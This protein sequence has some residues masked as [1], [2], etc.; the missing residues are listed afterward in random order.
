MTTTPTP[1][2]PA[3]R[4]DQDHELIEELRRQL[5]LYR[6]VAWGLEPRPARPPGIARQMARRL[7]GRY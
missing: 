5:R 7:R 6:G 1:P 3:G 2:R 4:S